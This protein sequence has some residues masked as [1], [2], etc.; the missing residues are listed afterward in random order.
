MILGRLP[1]IIRQYWAL[2]RER[3]WAT[4]EL[5]TIAAV[6]AVMLLLLMIA[7]RRP[8]EA[9]GKRKSARM[10]AGQPDLTDNQRVQLL[11][12]EIIKRDNTEAR[13]E[14]EIS[15]LAAANK[16]LRV[17]IVELT[18]VSEQL[19]QEES[20]DGLFSKQKMTELTLFN[21]QLRRD[22]AVGKKA[23]ERSG[24]E[25]A[26]LTV[27]NKQLQGKIAD[28]ASANEQLQ[29]EGGQTQES[30]EQKAGELM[31]VNEQLRQEVALRKEACERSEQEVA[32]VTAANKQ[33]QGKI[34][35][36]A[37]ANEQLQHEGGQAQESSDHKVA[38]LKVINEQLWQEVTA[39]KKASEYSKK[40]MPRLTAAEGQ[41][42]NDGA[43]QKRAVGKK[44]DD[45]HRKTAQRDEKLV[46]VSG[47]SLKAKSP[48]QQLR[49]LADEIVDSNSRKS[50][51]DSPD[52]RREA[53][54][55]ACDYLNADN[56]AMAVEALKKF[57]N[58]VEA[59]R[60]SNGNIL[61]KEE[62]EDWIGAAR[63]VIYLLTAG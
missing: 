49:E 28:L 62:A 11:Q 43:E 39:G 46:F 16:Q 2:I 63:E 9:S 60:G 10:I 40:E 15:E 41:F 38:E 57:I 45:R 59:N 20:G 3:Q 36:L 48:A 21:E 19:R 4:W 35:E 51:S 58:A 17:K 18:K 8:K 61:H 27:A 12:H 7:L 1:D 56:S 32:E 25:I 22:V 6:A 53:I 33:L 34:A 55:E 14:R 44:T 37:S 30:S 24:Q 31:V 47:I 26:E 50:V 5:L 13:F 52:A 29:H 42:E 54:Q 23:C